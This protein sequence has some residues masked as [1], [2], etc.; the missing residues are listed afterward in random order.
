MS[1]SEVLIF[2]SQPDLLQCFLKYIAKDYGRIVYRG[3]WRDA[4]R[5]NISLGS[6][7]YDLPRTEAFLPGCISG[8]TP[9]DAVHWVGET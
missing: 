6:D 8:R 7:V 4:A 5:E 1:F 3:E 2:L 9:S